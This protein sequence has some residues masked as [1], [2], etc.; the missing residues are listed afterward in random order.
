M[1]ARIEPMVGTKLRKKANNPQRSGKSTP[2]IHS[3]TAHT[4]KKAQLGFHRMIAADLVDNSAKL[5]VLFS[6]KAKRR[7]ESLWKNG[8]LD[9]HEQE[10]EQNQRGLAEET[11]QGAHH[12]VGK[13]HQS[14]GV[15]GS[16][17]GQLGDVSIFSRTG[18]G[19]AEAEN[20]GVIPSFDVEAEGKHNLRGMT[21]KR[22][23]GS[24]RRALI[25]AGV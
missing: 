11:S 20:R 5:A 12:G 16:L 17:F 15:E 7:R 22:A 2:R 19:Q 10:Q 3:E 9:K 13:P 23:F 25:A 24:W 4:G 14:L 8:R 18:R 21:A 1:A 6:G